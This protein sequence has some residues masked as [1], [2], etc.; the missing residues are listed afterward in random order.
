MCSEYSIYTSQ[1]CTFCSKKRL[2]AILVDE[3]QESQKLCLS[4]RYQVAIQLL[5]A[6]ASEIY[7]R[8]QAVTTKR[9]NV[10]R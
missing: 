9:L 1:I 6:T 4:G 7:M 8:T 5:V 2:S 3:Q 10:E